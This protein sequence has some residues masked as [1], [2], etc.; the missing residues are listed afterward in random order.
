MI[1]QNSLIS[2]SVIHCLDSIM[3][4]VSICEI[5]SLQLASVAAQAGLSRP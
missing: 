3:P 5:S 4:L 2:V 1:K